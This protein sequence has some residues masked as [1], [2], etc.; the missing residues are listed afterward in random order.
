MPF[1]GKKYEMY[2]NSN[3]QML[4]HKGDIKTMGMERIGIMI[5]T[6]EWKWIKKL[7]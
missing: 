6:Y 4:S 5:G 1:N 2:S 7:K 3:H